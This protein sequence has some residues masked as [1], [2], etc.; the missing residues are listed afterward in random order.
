MEQKIMEQIDKAQAIVEKKVK[1]LQER[2]DSLNGEV[3]TPEIISML[4]VLKEKYI[5]KMPLDE[6]IKIGNKETLDRIYSISFINGKYD[7]KWIGLAFN[8]EIKPRISYFHE[9]EYTD[10]HIDRLESKIKIIDKREKELDFLENNIGN[11]IDF[12]TEKYKEIV[13]KQVDR[14]ADILSE[15]D[16]EEEPIRHIKVTVEWL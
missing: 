2:Y 8:E 10:Y 12:I 13:E 5:Y 14:M 9:K 6:C 4:D 7:N 1:Y 16:Y 11:L 15:L 3:F